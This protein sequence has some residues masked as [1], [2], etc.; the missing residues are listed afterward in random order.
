[1]TLVPHS[2]TDFNRLMTTT[3]CLR[4]PACKEDG[5]NRI[6]SA[7][8]NKPQTRAT[9]RLRNNRTKRRN[10][11]TGW[12]RK[13]QKKFPHKPPHA[14]KPLQACKKLSPLARQTTTGCLRKSQATSVSPKMTIKPVQSYQIQPVPVQKL[15]QY[16]PKTCLLYTSPSP[17]D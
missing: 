9:G 8:V 5:H 6:Q 4:N 17:R 13:A 7:S 11:T 14:H 2:I 1:M 3:G 15:S 12:L 16:Q 10:I